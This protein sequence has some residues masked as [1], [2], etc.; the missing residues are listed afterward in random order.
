M[1][2]VGRT[3]LTAGAAIALSLA[4]ASPALADG[5]G[6]VK[7]GEAGNPSCDLGAGRGGHSAPIPGPAPGPKPGGPKSPAGEQGKVAPPPGDRVVGG[8]NNQ[9]DCA[10]VR[11]NYQPPANGVQTIRFH[12]HRWG[13][14]GARFVSLARPLTQDTV[15]A[16]GPAPGG[17]WYVYQCSGQGQRDALY[18]APVWIPD[19]QAPGAAPLPSPEELAQQAW[20]QLRLPS[21]VIGSSPA[22]TQLVQLPTWLWLNRAMW[23]PQSATASVPGVSVTATATPTS[24]S[25]VMGDG[26]TVSCAG[27]GTPFPAHGDPRAASPDC[28]HTYQRSS[29][30]A[31]GE[32]FPAMA[33]VSWRIT[34]SGAGASGTFPDL[35]TSATASF[36]VAEAQ[37]LGT[38]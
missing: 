28:G 25:W 21:P 12:R 1:H 37:A 18:R 32:R 14:G 4:A 34:W 29:A 17:A 26:S 13:S 16:Q 23:R 15:L 5:W 9:A 22:G 3:A 2:R 33:T 38:G 19:G 36:R 11:S 10:Y 27:T 8:A 31:P 6:N 7:C 20:S 30:S 35:T 24:V